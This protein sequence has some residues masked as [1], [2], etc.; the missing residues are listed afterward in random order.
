LIEYEDDKEIHRRFITP[1]TKL[2]FVD[3]V[4]AMGIFFKKTFLLFA[5]LSLPPFL[6]SGTLASSPVKAP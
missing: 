6:P 3:D 1:T 2:D 4:L 5:R